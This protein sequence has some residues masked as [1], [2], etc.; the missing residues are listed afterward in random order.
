M[1]QTQASAVTSNQTEPHEKLIPVVQKHLATDFKK[2]IAPFNQQAFDEAQAFIAA[3]KGKPIILDSCCGIG[4]STIKLAQQHKDAIVIGIDQSAHRLAK[5]TQEKQQADVENA[6]LLRANIEDFWRLALAAQWPIAKHTIF[7]PNPW[8]KSIHLKRRIHGSPVFASMVALGGE[9]ELR[10]NWLIYL[11]E[12][13]IA[14]ALANIPS[15]IKA[16]NN[17]EQQELLPPERIMTAFERKYNDA[18][19]QL[20]QLIVK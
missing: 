10:S 11:Q 12:C 7:Y 4:E 14:L 16:L 3:H 5:N 13:K 9:I 15:D 18:Q 6:L 1:S 20:W 8:P 17:P 2:P 19:Q